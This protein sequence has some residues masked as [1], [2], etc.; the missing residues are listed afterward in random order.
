VA[1]DTRISLHKL[2]VFCTVADLGNVSRAAEQLYVAQP[3]VSA[4]IKSLEQRVG[5]KLFERRENRMALTEAGEA[6]HAWATDVLT[7]SR[8]MDREIQGL[9]GGSHGAAAIASSMSVGSYILPEIVS[10]FR[11]ERPGARIT[12]DT[13]DP[14]HAAAS[15]EAGE[16]DFAV[17]VAEDDQVASRNL[18]LERLAEEQFILIA[19]VD[20]FPAADALTVKDL[21]T[22]PYVSSP[23]GLS[24]Q[25]MVNRKLGE[26]GLSSMNVV[27]ELGHP[28]SMKRAVRAGLGVAFMFQSSVAEEIKRGELREIKVLEANLRAPVLLVHRIDK[29]FTRMQMDLVNDV[30]TEV[31]KLRAP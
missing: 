1:L 21:T 4:H 3:V 24:R 19:G 27:I 29:R 12:V 30:R 23:V 6:A 26:I 10:A 8:E 2:E 7:R 22:L 5:A 15:A 14:E 17:L 18:R 11:R 9:A 28:E 31:A 25:R 16:C 20:S 13:S